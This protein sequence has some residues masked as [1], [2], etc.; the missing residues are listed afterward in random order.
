MHI[1]EFHRHASQTQ[2][3]L[4]ASFFP[5]SFRSISALLLALPLTC[6]A[7]LA[8]GQQQKAPL[9]SLTSTGEVHVNGVPAPPDSTIFAGDMVDTGE[10][11]SATFTISG[12]GDLKI[13]RQTQLAFSGSAQYAAELKAGTVVLD[14][15]SG[16]S[17]VTLLAGNYVVVP[18]ARDQIT[19]AKIDG[20]ANGAFRVSC[21]TGTVALVGLQGGSGQV[22]QSGEAINISSQGISPASSSSGHQKRWIILGLAGGGAAAGIAAAASHGSKQSVSPSTP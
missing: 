9:G 10:N 1:R 4:R 18:A 19:S 6:A 8:Q 14:S 17:G 16:P 2:A 5:R 12:K 3:I 20:P 22:L 15:S 11:G 21:L 7:A 13:S